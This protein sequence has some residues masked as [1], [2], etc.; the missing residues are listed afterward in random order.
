MG[1]AVSVVGTPRRYYLLQRRACDARGDVG[2]A[3]V[4]RYKQEQ[5]PGTALPVGL[6]GYDALV[7]A[8]YVA[9]ADVRGADEDELRRA[10]LRADEAAAVVAAYPLE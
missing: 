8:G 4:F 6:P 3:A 7:A 5:Q 10:G 1:P 2:L 9:D